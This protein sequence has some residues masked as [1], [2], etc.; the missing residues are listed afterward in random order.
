MRDFGLTSNQ[1]DASARRRCFMPS[2]ARRAGVVKPQSRRAFTIIESIATMTILAAIGSVASLI[3][4]TTMDSYTDGSVSA[5][6]HSELSVTMDRIV[7]EL[8]KIPRDE[9]AVDTAPDIASISASAITWN[10]NN[11]LSLSGSNLMYTESGGTAA[12]LQTDVTAFSIQAYDESDAAMAA[13]LSGTDCDPV[14]RLQI[15]LTAQ[16]HGVTETLRTRMFIRE[17]MIGVDDA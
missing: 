6:L 10:T 5:Q 13:S 7:R 3:I 11:T 14:R 1:A 15:I 17:T 8:R 4:Y 16:R 12:V 2:L 9:S